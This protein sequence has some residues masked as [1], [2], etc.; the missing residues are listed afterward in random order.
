MR[1]SRSQSCTMSFSL[2]RSIEHVERTYSVRACWRF[3]YKTLGT[4]M[5][6]SH[7]HC[8]YNNLQFSQ[9]FGLSLWEFVI[10]QSKGPLVRLVTDVGFKTSAH[11]SNWSQGCP[12][13]LKSGLCMG[14]SKFLFIKMVRCYLYEP[15]SVHLNPITPRTCSSMS[16]WTLLCAV[17]N[18]LVKG[19]I[20]EWGV[21]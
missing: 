20:M 2:S 19:G 7:Y 6:L 15:C 5:Q 9:V 10:M 21:S 4:N 3:H 12:V 1:K 14:H 11:S 17:S 18:H 16:S 8:N 13:G